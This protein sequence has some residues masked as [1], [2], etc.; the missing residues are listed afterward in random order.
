MKK[1]IAIGQ[2]WQE[3]N[4]FCPIKTNI[5]DFEQ[6]GLFFGKEII[7]KF[8]GINE[9]GGFIKAADEFEGYDIELLPTI[10][11]WAWP[12]GN[13]TKSAYKKIKSELINSLKK[14]LPLDGILLALHG[15]MVAEDI[16]DAEGDILETIHSEISKKLPI[17][18]SL[19]LHANI[20]EKMLA[21]TI[22]IE[23]YHTCPHMDLFK[24]GHKTAQVFFNI[25]DGK[26]NLKKGFVKIP[27]ITPARMHN[28][29]YGPFRK[30]FDY[31]EKI[32]NKKDVV[33]ASLFAVQPWLDVPELGWSV[34]VY[35][36]LN[37][38]SNSE[39]SKYKINNIGYEQNRKAQE[40]AE[41]ITDLV[42]QMRKEF[43][44]KETLPEIA[45]RK[46]SKM[47]RGLMV[48][49]D[50]DSTLSGGTGDNTCILSEL[51]NQNVKFPAILTIVDVEVVH[52]AIKI[53][54]GNTITCKIGGKMDRIFSKSLNITAN[55]KK[56]ID[57]KFLIDGHIGKNYVN[58]GK[59]AVLE[60]GSVIIL[61]S[62]KMGPVFEL[63]VYKSAGFNP[64]DFRVVVVKSPVGFRDAYEPIANEIILADCPGLSS[65]NLNNFNFRNI[66]HPFFPFDEL[67]NWKP[68]AI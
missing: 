35:V 59:V 1:R 15:A 66:T 23:G 32:E 64:V 10:R 18:V 57:G 54:S 38:D 9:L 28:T 49:S 21:N 29:N 2:V 44:I 4:T 5:A 52:K 33:S 42:W 30:I 11:A 16:F 58:V 43:F 41:E 31:L 26:L 17:A 53:G 39:N 61:V 20:T 68:P 55:I 65:S 13:V 48:I 19:D 56:I 14:S 63:N 24:T 22:F 51:I 62:E 34:I 8:T 3:Q 7:D 46:A 6:N 25:L 50:S 37:P 36:N 27:M 40:F 47:D 45:I 67:N 60:V 12:K